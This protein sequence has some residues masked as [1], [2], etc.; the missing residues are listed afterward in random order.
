MV[1]ILLSDNFLTQM[2][3]SDLKLGI[4]SLIQKYTGRTTSLQGKLHKII[5]TILQQEILF[6]TQGNML[7]CFCSGC[8]LLLEGSRQA[9]QDSLQVSTSKTHIS[10]KNFSSFC[11][12][13][14]TTL[15]F[16]SA[17]CYVSEMSMPMASFQVFDVHQQ[18]CKGSNFG[19]YIEKS[20]CGSHHKHGKVLQ[21]ENW[22]GISVQ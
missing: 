19:S 14:V 20:H 17:S 8:K 5:E 16:I 11:F 3:L 18:R 9:L 4:W 22:P 1:T 2:I 12:H 10:K 13:L 7:Q 6:F 21:L 15:D